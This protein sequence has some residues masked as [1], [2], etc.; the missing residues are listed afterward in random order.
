MA[1]G[2]KAMGEAIIANL[3][4]KTGKDLAQWS[5][6]LSQRGTTDP[7][8]ARAL[9]MDLGLGRFQ[10]VAVSEH[11]LGLNTYDNDADLIRTQFERFPEQRALY[12]K[13]VAALDTSVFIA[14]PC[15]GYLPIYQDGKIVVSFKATKRGLYAALNVRD[16]EEWPEC[17]VHK[18]SLGGSQRLKDG[19]FIVDSADVD[20]LVKELS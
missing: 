11:A 17:V 8:E 2:P 18:P 4:E 19:V 12:D 13:A 3:K 1:L 16:I 20:R 9:L 15:R 14:K 6:E 5:A 7:A 10:A